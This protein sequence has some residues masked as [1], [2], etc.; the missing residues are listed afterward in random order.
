MAKRAYPNPATDLVTANSIKHFLKPV[1]KTAGRY[2]G[3]WNVIYPPRWVDTT[4]AAQQRPSP[5]VVADPALFARYA[6]EWMGSFDGDLS[7]DVAALLWSLAMEECEL[8]EDLFEGVNNTLGST[9][10]EFVELPSTELGCDPVRGERSCQGMRVVGPEWFDD[11][12]VA[13]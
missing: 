7:A 4:A 6:A 11:E 1:T 5:I 3:C 8:L 12:E 10:G 13:T 9:L 2:F